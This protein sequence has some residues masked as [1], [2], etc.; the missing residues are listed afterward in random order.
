MDQ[1]CSTVISEGGYVE[2][3]QDWGTTTPSLITIASG[4]SKPVIAIRLKQQFRSYKNR[5]IVRMGNLN[6]F[7]DGDSVVWK[8]VKLPGSAFLT[9]N[10][11]AWVDVNTNSGVQFNTDLSS[12]TD[13]DEMDNGFVGAS[14]QGSQKAAGSPGSNLPSQAKKNFIVQN[15]D[16]TDSEIFLVWAKNL[17]SQSTNVGVGLQW[18]EIY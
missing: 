6:V 1:I 15:Y 12:Y 16:S 13:G 3:G 2:A 8:L 17:G 9:A 10:A 5:M 7:S 18:R 4:S 11:N 14:T